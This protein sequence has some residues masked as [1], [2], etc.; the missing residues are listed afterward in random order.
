[1]GPHFQSRWYNTKPAQRR[2]SM[3]YGGGG[4]GDGWSW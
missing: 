4:D 2:R 1:M 3:W